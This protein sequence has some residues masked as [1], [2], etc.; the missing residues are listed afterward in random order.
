MAA[1]TT[2]TIEIYK[3]YSKLVKNGLYHG[4]WGIFEDETR[5]LITEC[6]NCRYPTNDPFWMKAEDINFSIKT[7][8]QKAKLKKP[9]YDEVI[10]YFT[11][12]VEKVNA[13]YEIK[14]TDYEVQYMTV[15][16]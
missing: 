10:K 13:L 7:R 15:T 2:E 9:K 5:K 3:P 16:Y 1:E 11:R 4:C 14:T 6:S 12:K 8:S